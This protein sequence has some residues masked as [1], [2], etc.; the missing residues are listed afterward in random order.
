M[1][2]EQSPLL[3]MPVVVKRLVALNPPVKQLPP[4]G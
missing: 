3:A 4:I 2:H 1:G